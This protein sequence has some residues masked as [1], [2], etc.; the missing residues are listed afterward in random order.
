MQHHEQSVG[1]FL[2]AEG[3]RLTVYRQNCRTP[4]SSL[5]LDTCAFNLLLSGDT[6]ARSAAAVMVVAARN[7]PAVTRSEVNNRR[8]FMISSFPLFVFF[9]SPPL[10]ELNKI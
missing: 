5:I 1:G 7:I 3:V 8:I 4:A 2:G 10:G 6:A 9:G